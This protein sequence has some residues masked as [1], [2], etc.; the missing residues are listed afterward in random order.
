MWMDDL[1]C[2]CKARGETATYLL[3]MD[4]A[5]ATDAIVRRSRPRRCDLNSAVTVSVDPPKDGRYGR[6]MAPAAR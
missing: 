6:R 3:P 1:P 2:V 4:A 5:P